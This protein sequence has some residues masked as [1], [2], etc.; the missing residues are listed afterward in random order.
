MPSEF[1]AYLLDK[2][3]CGTSNNDLR[4]IASRATAAY[5]ASGTPLNESLRT[6]VKE[7][8]LNIEQIRRVV[9]HANVD[10]NLALFKRGF[11]KNVTFPVADTA[12]VADMS[13]V[14]TASVRSGYRA[15][16]KYIPGS[17]G[18]RFDDFFG[19]PS[20]EKV[21]GVSANAAAHKLSILRREARDQDSYLSGLGV[22][23]GVKLAE[24]RG[25]VTK[26]MAEGDTPLTVGAAMEMALAT[27]P[28]LHDVLAEAFGRDVE[29]G[30]HLKLAAAGVMMMPNNP[31]TG[32]TQDL[33][34]IAAKMMSASG[35]LDRT[36][37]AMGELV[38]IL[39]GQMP[40]QPTSELFQAGG[41]PPGAPPPGAMP[42]GAQMQGPPGPPM[43][44]QPGPPGAPQ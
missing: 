22:E 4:D 38:Q 10:T 25:E 37:M 32:L 24:I 23:F 16:P 7:A 40:M 31:V 28:G 9:E 30:G 12:A 42:P 15:A 39:Q 33:D 34:Q 18:V 44:P 1:E 41:A 3:A 27:S 2:S 26:A 6:L 14:K 19:T 21:A 29:F 36:R 20:K 43:P 13:S 17:E 8:G 5:L 35:A 11:E